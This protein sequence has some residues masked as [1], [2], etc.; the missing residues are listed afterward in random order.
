MNYIDDYNQ[1]Q[2]EHEY[3]TERI[4]DIYRYERNLK[5][6]LSCEFGEGKHKSGKISM[7]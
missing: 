1:C 4:K 5:L 6:C 7:S 3:S 2:A